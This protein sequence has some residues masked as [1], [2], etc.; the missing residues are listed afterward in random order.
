MA[1]TELRTKKEKETDKF[2]ILEE[3]KDVNGKKLVKTTKLYNVTSCQAN[4]ISCSNGL[5]NIEWFEYQPAIINQCSDVG[6]VLNSKNIFIN[7]KAC[8]RTDNI[9]CCWAVED[10]GANLQ[11]RANEFKTTI[12]SGESGVCINLNDNGKVKSKSISLKNVII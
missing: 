11:N 2:D 8:I 9:L 3:C 5:Q 1:V 6:V 7:D 4:N 10:G 12:R